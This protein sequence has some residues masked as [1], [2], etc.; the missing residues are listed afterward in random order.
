MVQNL[1]AGV[2]VVADVS[3]YTFDV[4]HVAPDDA[5][6]LHQTDVAGARRKWRK[7]CP[8]FNKLPPA[9]LLPAGRKNDASIK[10]LML[11]R[12][13]RLAKTLPVVSTNKSRTS[14]R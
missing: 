2:A 6:D 10:L 9:T 14:R 1:G 8:A 5:V 12:Q 11:G 3:V 4:V 7:L 13:S